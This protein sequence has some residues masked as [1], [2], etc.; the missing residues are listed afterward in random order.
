MFLLSLA[1]VERPVYGI[2]VAGDGDSFRIGETR[3]RLF[4]IDAPEF[5]QT[6][7]RDGRT[8]ACGNASSQQ[9]SKLITGREVRCVPMSTD[10]YGRVVVKCSVGD[11]DINRTM[12]ASGLA[13]A[14]RRYSTE[15][16]S[17]E[18]AAR[19]SRRGLWVGTFQMPSEVRA[20][21]RRATEPAHP[22]EANVS[23]ARRSSGQP[24]SGCNIKGNHSRHGDW[25]YHVPGMPYYDR[26]RAEQMFCSEADARAAGYR[27]AKVL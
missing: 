25:I 9:L 26:T 2:A 5:D 17:A 13:V 3:Y 18:D 23:S 8:W 22:R 27:R 6:C 4:G 15:Y 10:A 24:S 7:L 19:N 20:A 16:V 21:S 1:A 12:V 11:T 14:F